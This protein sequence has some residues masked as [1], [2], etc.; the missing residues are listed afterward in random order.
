MI[1]AGAAIYSKIKQERAKKKVAEQ[2]LLSVGDSDVAK[3][4]FA[5]QA[6]KTTKAI[7]DGHGGIQRAGTEIKFEDPAG[8]DVTSPAASSPGLLSP[9]LEKHE[10]RVA[11]TPQ[12]NVASPVKSEKGF[13]T[14]TTPLSPVTD[15]FHSRSRGISEPLHFSTQSE[16]SS[17]SPSA[18]SRDSDGATL[19]ESDSTSVMATSSQGTYVVKVRTIGSDLKSGFPYH[20]ALFDMQVHPQKWDAFTG[21]ITSVAKFGIGDHAQ[22]VASAMAV[23]MVG[24]FGTSVFVGRGVA[25]RM[26]EKK[27][28][29]GLQDTSDGGLGDTLQHWNESYFRGRGLFVHLE[30]SES[31]MKRPDQQ[32][33][34][35]RK[36]TPWYGNKEERERKKAERKFVL[37]VTR[38]DEDGEPSQA[39]HELSGGTEAAIIPELAGEEDA[40]YNLAEMPGDECMIPVELPGDM[41]LPWGVSLGYGNDKAEPGA[42]YAELESDTTQLLGKARLDDE[43]DEDVIPLPLIVKGSTHEVLNKELT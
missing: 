43:E 13:F 36:E 5:S 23:A 4:A 21:Q 37:V 18:Y 42:G 1:I 9:T 24:A 29:A 34:L 20:P 39:L 32:S 30:L 38:L 16:A 15:G 22:V 6:S 3:R 19:A 40:R 14:A 12:P 2:G 41:A 31:A 33:R 11:P 7:E 25:R 8:L 27:I 17:Q 10:T 28:K 35:F 26:E